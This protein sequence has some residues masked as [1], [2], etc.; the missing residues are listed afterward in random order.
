MLGDDDK[1]EI[2]IIR[3]SWLAS[4]A[5]SAYYSVLTA[6]VIV[7]SEV[8]TS[9]EDKKWGGHSP[10]R[11]YGAGHAQTVQN[12]NETSLVVHSSSGRVEM[13]AN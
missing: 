3:G 8:L 4:G 7:R 11:R 12:E 6:T 10:G 2:V 5:T 1:M 9:L 13:I